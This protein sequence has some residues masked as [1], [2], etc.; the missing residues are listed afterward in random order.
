[1]I[2]HILN[3][4]GRYPGIGFLSSISTVILTTGTLQFIGAVLGVVIA[5]L[6]IGIKIYEIIEHVKGKNDMKIGKD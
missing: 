3:F 6:T 2:T 5:V 4:F 1:M